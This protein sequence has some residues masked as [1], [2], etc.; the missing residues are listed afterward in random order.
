MKNDNAA[1]RY[2][3]EVI[4]LDL[5][6]GPSVFAI[7][8]ALG[9]LSDGSVETTAAGITRLFGARAPMRI[10][11]EAGTHSPWVSRLLAE[12]GHEVIVANPRQVALIYRSKRKSDRLDAVT[13][14]R[15]ARSD[16]EL[17]H[18]LRH[19]S[20]E[21]QQHL[22]VLR[23]REAL[24][25]ARTQLINHSRGM[26]KS[27]GFRLPKCSAEAFPAKAAAAMP[28]ELASL[29]PVLDQIA[30]ISKGVRGYDREVE[31][32][33][34]ERYPEARALRQ[35]NGVGPITS[36]AF[37]L[38][39]EDPSR[40]QTSRDVPA[41]LGLTPAR[42]QTGSSDP[43]LHITH[44]GDVLL[45]K[46]LVQSAHYILGPFGKMSDLRTFGLRKAGIVD[47]R[48]PGSRQ[49]KKKAVVAVARKLAVLLHRLWVTGAPYEPLRNARLE[50]A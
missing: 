20:K 6:D 41:Y 9:E 17:L 46:L 15:L 47:H 4:G 23:S 49:A 3:G 14:A 13:L 28:S 50:A 1:A 26:A 48:G 10:A 45:R 22:A 34:R 32:L 7:L 19:R 37:V 12:L 27:F 38:T 39:L 5:S 40:F 42:R 44:A 36:L 2:E 24:V 8:S 29:M 31:R 30:E 11:I 18:P 21:S 43:E 33:A 16:S 25:T 35:V